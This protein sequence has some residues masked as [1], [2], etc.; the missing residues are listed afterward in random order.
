VAVVLRIGVVVRDANV[1]SLTACQLNLI[2]AVIHRN[3][4]FFDTDFIP[5]NAGRT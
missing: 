1:I 2:K 4:S 5:A 3:S